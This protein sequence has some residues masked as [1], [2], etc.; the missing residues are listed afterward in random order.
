MEGRK[1]DS[2][3]LNLYSVTHER[4][5]FLCEFHADLVDYLMDSHLGF[6]R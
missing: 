6:E 5:V 2:A 1:Q 3:I 4:G